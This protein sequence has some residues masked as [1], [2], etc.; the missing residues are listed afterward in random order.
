[1]IQLILD[2]R[3]KQITATDFLTDITEF[4]LMLSQAQLYLLRAQGCL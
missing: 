3:I 1:M 2:H 4:A